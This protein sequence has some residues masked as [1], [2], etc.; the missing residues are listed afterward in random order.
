ME[1]GYARRGS[2]AQARRELLRSVIVTPISM[3]EA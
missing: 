1:E 3:L 2:R